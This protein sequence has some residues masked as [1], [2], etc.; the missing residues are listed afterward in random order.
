MCACWYLPIVHFFDFKPG[1]YGARKKPS[2]Q[3]IVFCV[4]R[5]LAGLVSSLH[6]SE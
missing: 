2:I 4:P 1:M 3:R 6:L 5:P